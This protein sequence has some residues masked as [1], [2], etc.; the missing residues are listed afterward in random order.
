MQ[1]TPLRENELLMRYLFK[2]ELF[3]NKMKPFGYKIGH[4]THASKV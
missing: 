2:T 4:G 1:K 3:G